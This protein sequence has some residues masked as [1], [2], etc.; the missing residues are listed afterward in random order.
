MNIG[1]LMNCIWYEDYSPGQFAEKLNMDADVFFD[2]IYLGG[3][4]TKEEIN[5]ISEV[6][7]LTTEET[8]MIFFS[9]TRI[10]DE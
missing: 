1:L 3:G 4:F 10:C 9:D 8:E 2:K 5:K 7:E 6:L